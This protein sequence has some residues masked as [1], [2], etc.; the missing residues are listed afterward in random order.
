MRPSPTLKWRPATAMGGVAFSSDFR[1]VQP[2]DPQRGN[3]R[4]LLDILNRGKATALRNLNSAPDVLPSDPLDPGQR[5]PDAPGVFSGLVRLAARRPQRARCPGH[6]SAGRRRRFRAD[7]RENRSHL[8][9]Q[10]SNPSPASVRPEPPGISRQQS[11]GPR[12]R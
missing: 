12:T 2:V 9:E 11:G 10:C 6:E 3:G 5:F 7:F 1:V 8:P 4:M